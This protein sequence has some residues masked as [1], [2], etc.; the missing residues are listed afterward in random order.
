MAFAREATSLYTGLDVPQADKLVTVRRLVEA[1][2]LAVRSKENLKRATELSDRHLAYY[3]RAAVVLGV[4]EEDEDRTL[5]LG[6]FA[7]RLLATTTGSND[8]RAVFMEAILAAKA[9]KPFRSLFAT[10]SLSKKELTN[11]IIAIT[12]MSEQTARRR[13][14]TLLAWKRYV[15]PKVPVDSDG[16]TFDDI[17]SDIATRI[18]THNEMVK[19]KY[20]DWLRTAPP[21]KLEHLSARLFRALAGFR[22]VRKVGGSGDGGVDVR[23]T[24]V[25]ETGGHPVVIQV[26]RY[27][28][29]IQVNFVVNLIG[30]M[31]VERCPEAFLITTSGFSKGAIDVARRARGLIH[32]VDGETLLELMVEH[33]IGLCR[34]TYGEIVRETAAATDPDEPRRQATDA[35]VDAEPL[36]VVAKIDRA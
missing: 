25:T 35:D 32:L 33:G 18:A 30:V 6:P 19:Q 20:L 9:L 13:A 14:G 24:R 31:D 36:P 10:G 27:A 11:R 23:A 26:K 22:D 29:N 3:R 15:A 2:N 12:G 7:E 1:V 4:L 16:P 28:N 8:E 34:G 5:S 17:T 21:E